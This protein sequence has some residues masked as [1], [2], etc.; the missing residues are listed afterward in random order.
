[1]SPTTLGIA[2]PITRRLLLQSLPLVDAIVRNDVVIRMG[3]GIDNGVT[4]G[5]GASEQPTGILNQSGIGSVTLAAPANLDLATYNQFEETV[6][7]ANAGVGSF[8]FLGQPSWITAGKGKTVSHIIDAGPPAAA[9]AAGG[10][11]MLIEGS[12]VT[13]Y[14]GYDGYPFIPTTNMTS[15]GLLMKPPSR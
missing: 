10:G 12:M 11:R 6:L 1:M 9:V 7:N 3:D 5:S 4:E 2:V 8:G 15:A 14:R 13:G